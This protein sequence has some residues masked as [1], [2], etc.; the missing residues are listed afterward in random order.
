[1]SPIIYTARKFYQILLDARFR[2]PPIN[3]DNMFVIC[4]IKT[5]TRLSFY[6]FSSISPIKYIYNETTIKNI[7]RYGTMTYEILF[8]GV[9]R[10]VSYCTIIVNKLRFVYIVYVVCVCTVSLRRPYVRTHDA[11]WR[12]RYHQ[13]NVDVSTGN[14]AR[15][16]R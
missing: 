4:A 10:N 6:Y 14:R 8:Y 7:I 15:K 1:M 13:H 2:I 5:Y 11:L 9:Y 12:T 3:N 16:Y